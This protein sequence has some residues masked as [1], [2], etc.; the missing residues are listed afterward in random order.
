MADAAAAPALDDLRQAVAA[1]KAE[2]AKV[3]AALQ[4]GGDRRQRR[5]LGRQLEKCQ[6]KGRSLGPRVRELLEA[7]E[8][9][10][11]AEK[12]E[13]ALADAFLTMLQSYKP[14]D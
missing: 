4:L 2:T 5:E 12:T 8:G 14:G 6:R 9:L 13:L 10:P 7:A 3:V 1:L 11:E